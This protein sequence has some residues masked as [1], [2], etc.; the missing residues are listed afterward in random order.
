MTARPGTLLSWATDNLYATGPAAGGPTKS[1]PSSG[2]QATGYA[3]G[4]E[5]AAQVFNSLLNNMFSWLLWLSGGEWDT[6]FIVDGSLTVGGRPLTFA[7]RTFT[8]AS[9]TEQLTMTAHGLA[10][11]DGPFQLT[12][13]GTLPG[14]LAAATN[15]WTI[16]VDADHVKLARSLL[17]AIAG[18]AIDLTSNGTGTHTIAGA[19]PTHAAD[20]VGSRSLSVPGTVSTGCALTVGGLPITFGPV[21]FTANATFDELNVVGHGLASGDGP[22][23]V[24]NSGG[25]LPTG[26]IAATNYWAIRTSEDKFK[27][28]TSRAKSLAGTAID[29]TTN[30][31]G[32]NTVTAVSATRAASATVHGDVALDGNVSAGTVAAVD[33]QY[34]LQT[35]AVGTAGT[36]VTQSGGAATIDTTGSVV[37]SATVV[38]VGSLPLLVGDQIHSVSAVFDGIAS[39]NVTDFHVSLIEQNGT[40]TSLGSTTVSGLTGPV[41][42]TVA[43]TPTT[44]AVDQSFLISISI[45]ASGVH[46]RNINISRDRPAP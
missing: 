5:P 26:L 11:G 2:E 30:G 14:E 20:I 25:A 12:T 24:S 35:L 41:T 18:L 32:T 1:T 38:L 33:F 27:L 28:A 7:S 34:G 6:D 37:T 39:Q 29:L 44:L 10:T 17:G 16:R 22:L 31:T 8:A 43:C 42:A 13:T 19:S 21:T 23:Q 3:P 36:L 40:A 45:N 4:A 15:Y 9:T 46:V